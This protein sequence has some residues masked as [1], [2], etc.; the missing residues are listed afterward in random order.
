[1]VVLYHSKK[2]CRDLGPYFLSSTSTFRRTNNLFVTMREETQSVLGDGQKSCSR[3][4]LK[5]H[6]SWT[7][8]RLEID[9]QIRRDGQCGIGD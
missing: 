9:D 1:M 4:A 3:A 2:W 8:A 5:L 6:S 7:T